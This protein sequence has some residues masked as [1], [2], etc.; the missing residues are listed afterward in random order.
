M[1]APKVIPLLD[2]N[3]TERG[4]NGGKAMIGTGVVSVRRSLATALAMGTMVTLPAIAQ[5]LPSEMS[6][7]GG[8]YFQ[9][10]E[11]PKVADQLRMIATSI[12]AK[13]GELFRRKDPAGLAAIYT[14]DATFVEILPRIQV[15]H[16]RLEIQQHFKDLLAAGA[17]DLVFTVTQAQP[18][19]R[20]AMQAG[21]DYYINVKDGKR[22][23]GHFFQILHQDGGDWK[24]ALHFFARPEA[25]TAIE[26]LQYNMS[27]GS[28]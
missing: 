21:G 16:G 20:D 3:R 14:A 1:A 2:P 5:Q 25:V 8:R 17:G 27:S 10:G 19:S 26:A 15:M 13:R 11:K 9:K 22:I 6:E 23:S 12:N 7:S 24:I 28:Q 4:A 18:I